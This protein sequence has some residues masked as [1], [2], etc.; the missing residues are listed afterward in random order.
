MTLSELLA[1]AVEMHGS[2]VHLTAGQP[3]LVRV[4]GDLLRLENHPV[5]SSA[6]IEQV[7]GRHL[8]DRQQE[9]FEQTSELDFSTNIDAIA[10]IRGN[11]FRQRGGAAAVFRLIPDQVPGVS[12]LGLP[13]SV[14]KFARLPRGLVLVTGP[15]GSG[16]TTTLAAMIDTINS[17][18]RCHILT[19]ED[20][21]EYVHEPKV[22][23]VS[24]R[25]VRTDTAGFAPAL[26]AA[27]R[28]D[29]DV[30]LIGE[31]R[32]RETVQAALGIA[33][34]GHLTLATLHTNSAIQTI[35]RIIDLFPSHI[36]AHVRAQLSLVLQGIACQILA[37]RADG[38]GR[39]A[40]VEV[41]VPT[42]GVRHLIRED[43]LHQVYSAMQSAPQTAGMQT[44]N[45]AL[46]ALYREGRLTLESAVA[47]SSDQE[48]LQA[49]ITRHQGRT[50]V[51]RH[52]R[53]T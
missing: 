15:T 35:H 26:R 23:V 21:I 53:T 20:P 50:G 4:H 12:A 34:T 17:E 5:L 37:P 22:G 7:V 52:L 19:I 46:T 25:E 31:M 32:D 48:E 9:Q 51:N 36:Q 6:D 28:E 24:Q 38:H 43:K 39:V 41:L 1:V 27:L 3:P 2:D 45:Q 10:R 49:M 14:M 8:T 40:A 11:L 30:V 18:R 33:E 13:S 16:K 42:S 29:P 44:M 47:A